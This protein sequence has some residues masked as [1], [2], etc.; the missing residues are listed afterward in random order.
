MKYDD[1][2]AEL[3][4]IITRNQ[5]G[6]KKRTDYPEISSILSSSNVHIMYYNRF[7]KKK[8]KR[9]DKKE[10]RKELEGNERSEW[11]GREKRVIGKNETKVH[12]RKG[13][14]ERIKRKCGKYCKQR[15]KKG[16]PERKDKERK[17]KNRR[18]NFTI[19]PN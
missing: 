11:K 9:K 2:F 18:S 5:N 10:E 14:T 8:D 4:R 15:R 16:K 12:G 3:I 13:E 1:G 19:Q 7:K 6:K 17:R